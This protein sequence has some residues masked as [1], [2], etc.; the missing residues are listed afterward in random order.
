MYNAFLKDYV[1]TA[2]EFYSARTFWLRIHG[3]KRNKNWN[4]PRPTMHK[5][6][7]VLAMLMK[8]TIGS[9]FIF[10]AVNSGIMELASKEDGVKLCRVVVKN[11][12][13]CTTDEDSEQLLLFARIAIMMCRAG[14]TIRRSYAFLFHAINQLDGT[15]NP[16]KMANHWKGSR[17]AKYRIQMIHSVVDFCKANY[18]DFRSAE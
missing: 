16:F 14:I 5:M 4:V 11:G 2:P 10:H 13:E 8:G 15:P 18:E 3:Y 7:D 17:A 1:P 12:L 9:I 6:N